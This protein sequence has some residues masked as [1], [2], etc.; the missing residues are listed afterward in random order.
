MFFKFHRLFYSTKDPFNIIVF[1]DLKAL[2]FTMADRKAL[3]NLNHCNLVVSK[4]G[5]FHA[6]SMILAKESINLM[7]MFNFGMFHPNGIEP[8]ITDNV[9]VK[10]LDTLI[11][12][13]DEWTGYEDIASKMKKIQVNKNKN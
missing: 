5:R 9:F 2:G 1:E 3:L 6:S 10:G 7:E 8:A 11:K 12:V 13:V 4:L